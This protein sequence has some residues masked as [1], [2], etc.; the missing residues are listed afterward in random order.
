MGVDWEETTIGEQATLQS[1][2]DITKAEQRDGSVPVISSGGISS[3]HDES[4]VNGP[5]VVLG[6]KGVVGSVYYVEE[7]YWPHD[8]TLWVKNFH[9]NQIRFVYY[10]Y[11]AIAGRIAGMDVGSANPTLNRNHV[12]PIKIR[13]PNFATQQRI[14]HI[15]GTLDDKIELNRRMNET[16]E[17][18]ARALFRGWFVDFDP[19]RARIDGRPLDQIPG[20]DAETAALFPDGFEESPLGPIPKGWEALT[21]GD[22][23]ENFSAPFDFAR[24]PEPVFVNTG[25]VL[26]GDFL[27]A[28]R[29]QHQGLPGQAKKAISP[30]DILMSEIRPTNRRF[31]YVDFDSS[32]YVI[33]TKFI[34]VRASERIDSRLLYR[35]LTSHEI[36]AEFQVQAES[37]SGTFPQITFDSVSYL[38]LV[39]PPPNIQKA[40]QKSVG[41]FDE[42]I[43]GN[44]GESRTLATLRDTLLPKLLSGEITVDEVEPQPEAGLE[45]A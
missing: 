34:V 32:E 2:F 22:V 15:L 31:A 4:R 9:G 27:H 16:L 26:G 20:V 14:A 12:H 39:V 18:M 38:P 8:T 23:A 45:T 19:V 7:N 28:N 25:D 36:L 44:K 33:S 42:R 3:H 1:G 37:R 40:F 24:T 41:R 17:A 13:W 29:S 5:G 10:F 35:V 43:K 21:L 11:R 6:R 30:D